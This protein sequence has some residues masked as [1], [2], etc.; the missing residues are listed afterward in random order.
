MYT[1]KCI[2][3]LNDEEVC[4]QYRDQTKFMHSKVVK[5]LSNLK[6]SVGHKFK[7][8]YNKLCHPD[9]NSPPARFCGLPK[10]T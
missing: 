7:E 9:D 1:E 3:L 5:Q 10:N 2:A 4:K 8:Q 6:I